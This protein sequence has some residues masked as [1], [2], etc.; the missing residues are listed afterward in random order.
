MQALLVWLKLPGVRRRLS[1]I[2][3]LQMG[4]RVL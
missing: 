2:T 1:R 3:E 4:L